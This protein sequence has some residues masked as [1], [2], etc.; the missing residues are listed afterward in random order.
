MRYVRRAV[1]DLL[2]LCYHAVSDGWPTPLAVTRSALE[3]Q[4]ELLLDRGYR[5]VSFSEA[6]RSPPSGPRL[7]VT[8]DDAYQSVLVNARPVLDGLGLPGTVFVPTDFPDRPDRPMSWRGI[9]QWLGS[10]H[11]D[12]LRPLS[13]DQLAGLAEG[14]WELGSHTRSHPR[15]PGLDDARLEAELRGS[16]A[17]LERALG[18]PCHAL[19]YPYGAWDARVAA[20]AERAGYLA[21][22]TLLARIH[23]RREVGGSAL[24]LGWPRVGVY[25]GDDMPRFRLKV[26]RALRL[27]RTFRWAGRGSHPAF[28]GGDPPTVPS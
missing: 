20:A 8:F 7:A 15:L 5:G 16:R 1:G 27:I 22:G 2:I 17:V 6:F 11:E 4:L 10:E 19:A 23:R 9:D 24:P 25:R 13:W 18:R 26:S 12:E 3:R 14:G 21:A 28:R